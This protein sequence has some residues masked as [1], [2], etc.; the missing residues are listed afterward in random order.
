MVPFVAVGAPASRTKLLAR[1]IEPEVPLRTVEAADGPPVAD[2]CGPGGLV[3]EL[4]MACA[5]KSPAAL[6]TGVE[7]TVVVDVV[8]EVGTGI[9]GGAVDESVCTA[10][11]SAG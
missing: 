6:A 11:T 9:D 5:E 10:A 3:V 4:A 2:V 1:G 7:G 8:V